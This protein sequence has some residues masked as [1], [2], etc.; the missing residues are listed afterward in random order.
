M[1]LVH[2]GNTRKQNSWATTG[3]PAIASHEDCSEG[4]IIVANIH[5]HIGK[6]TSRR[7]EQGDDISM[8]DFRCR[9]YSDGKVLADK[10]IRE[11]IIKM[12]IREVARLTEIHSDTV[13]LVAKGKPVKPS[14]L[15]RVVG[16]LR[17]QN[18]K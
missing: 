9:E 16:F 15:A 10:E 14:T 5:R 18:D 3:N 6:E 2:T 1:F 7:W 8:V 13:T 12:G 4:V 17:P 11:R